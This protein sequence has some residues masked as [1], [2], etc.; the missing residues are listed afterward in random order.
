[1]DKQL[2]PQVVELAKV[3]SLETVYF[4]EFEA[5]NLTRSQAPREASLDCSVSAQGRVTSAT[6]FEAIASCAVE[7]TGPDNA[8]VAEIRGQ[9]CLKYS[10]PASTA[11]KPEVV[12]AFAATNG[13]YHAWPY[14]REFVQSMSSRLNLPQIVLPAMRMTELLGHA[15]GASKSRAKPQRAAKR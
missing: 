6:T 11:L 12:E 14:W 4:K 5:R 15:S 3:I 9:L 8:S 7:A 10:V 13:L 2:F 1:M